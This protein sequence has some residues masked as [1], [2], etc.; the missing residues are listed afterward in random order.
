MK[1]QLLA[2]AVLLLLSPLAFA[3]EKKQEQKVLFILGAAAE[4][5]LQKGKSIPGP[6]CF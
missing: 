1:T 3:Q 5:P 2:L 4:L 6:G